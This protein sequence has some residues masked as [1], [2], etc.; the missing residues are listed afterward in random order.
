MTDNINHP[1][2]YTD[3]NIGYECIDIAQYQSFCTGNV[4]K[5]LWRYNSKGTPLENLRKARWYAT[6]A[7]TMQENV[8]LDI[9]QCKTIL[10]RLLETTS[11]YESAAWF[12]ILENKWIIVL[13]ALDMMIGRTGNDPQAQ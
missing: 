13:S 10:Q 8:N 9:S 11:G 3:R 1:T 4:I 6:K 5:Y 12:G 2:H 7:N